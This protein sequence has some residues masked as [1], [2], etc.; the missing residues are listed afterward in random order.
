MLNVRLAGKEGLKL[1]S[2]CELQLQGSCVREWKIAYTIYFF[3]QRL[4]GNLSSYSCV[5][6]NVA[7]GKV[8]EII[9]DKI[10]SHLNNYVLIEECQNDIVLCW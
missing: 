10:S 4:R 5:S 1:E 8:L 9:T 7:V 3:Q 6:L 2:P